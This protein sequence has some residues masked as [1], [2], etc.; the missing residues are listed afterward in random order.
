M[1]EVALGGPGEARELARRVLARL[2]APDAGAAVLALSGELGAGK[3]TLTQAIATELGLGG[4]VPS[5]TFT[6]CRRHSLPAGASFSEVFHFDWY[7]LGGA[8]DLAAVGWAE[9]LATPRALVV[10]EWPERAPEAIPE[11]AV[12]VFLAH[13]AHPEERLARVT[14]DGSTE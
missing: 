2:V 4:V 1:E 5:P 6:V 10:V 12:R 3:T 7:R 8:E 9:A 14:W 13:G 11:G